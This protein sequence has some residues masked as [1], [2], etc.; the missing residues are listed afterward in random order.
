MFV[1]C[2]SRLSIACAVLGGVLQGKAEARL[3]AA[4]PDLYPPRARATAEAREAV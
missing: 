4:R 3:I 1:L 2:W